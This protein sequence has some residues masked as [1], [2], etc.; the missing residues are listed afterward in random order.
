MSKH[1]RTTFNCFKQ[2]IKKM[3]EVNKHRNSH[4]SNPFQSILIT[5]NYNALLYNSN[6]N[7]RIKLYL[8]LLE[9][10]ID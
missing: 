1:N 5:Y 7:Q 4:I 8:H 9:D 6:T 3:S 10:K 2:K